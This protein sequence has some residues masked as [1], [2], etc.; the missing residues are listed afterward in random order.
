M[1]QNWG[2]NRAQNNPQVGGA[3]FL[4]FNKIAEL[5]SKY[6]RAEIPDNC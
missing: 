6:P 3:G 5:P 4:D 2:Q 1:Q